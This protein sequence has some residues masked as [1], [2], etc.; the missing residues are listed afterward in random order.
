MADEKNIPVENQPVGNQRHLFPTIW[1]WLM[2][3]ANAFVAVT[4][5]LGSASIRL[6]MPAIPSW[7]IF[8][9]GAIA[10]INIICAVAILKWKMWGFWGLCA[11]AILACILNIMVGQS[12]VAAILG[13]FLGVLILYWSLNVGGDRKVWPRL[14]Q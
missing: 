10:V 11:T 12:I 6:Q 2:I 8:V 4:Y 1:L 5:F 13:S 3:V 7:F 14:Q 9:T